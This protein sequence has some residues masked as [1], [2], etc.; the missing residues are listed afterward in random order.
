MFI[1]F[2]AQWFQSYCR[3]VVADDRETIRKQ[4]S[5]ANKTIRKALRSAKLSKADRK[6]LREALRY[7]DLTKTLELKKPSRHTESHRLTRKSA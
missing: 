4:F 2:D 6:A 3:A 7:I 1:K 5:L